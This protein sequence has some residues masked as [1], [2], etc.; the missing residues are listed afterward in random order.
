MKK[1]IA[2]RITM[3]TL[4]M[5]AIRAIPA[6]AATSPALTAG[7][8]NI[9]VN[10]MSTADPFPVTS[11]LDDF[12]RTDGSPGSNWAAIDPLYPVPNIANGQLVAN[13]NASGYWTSMPPS[14]QEV[15]LHLTDPPVADDYV[16]MVRIGGTLATGSENGYC[17][18]FNPSLSTVTIKR[19]DG[20][21]KTVIGGPYNVIPGQWIGFRAAGSTLTA[22]SS[23]DDVTWNA[24][25]SATDATY[26]DGFIG[27][28]VTAFA[29][30]SQ[31]A[32]DDFGGTPGIP[33]PVNTAV[34]TIS[35]TTRPGS[36]LTA[37]KGSWNNSPTSYAYQW[38]R[39]GSNIPVATNPTYKIKTTDQGTTVTVTVTAT[40]A[41][42]S[43]TATRP[44]RTFPPRRRPTSRTAR[45]STNGTRTALEESEHTTTHRQVNR[46]RPS[47][48]RTGSTGWC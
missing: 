18:Y 35:G 7:D 30:G 3:A 26:T 12:A 10:Y 27:W 46:S 13:N 42:G 24:V 31:F 23:S 41:N 36:T 2:V 5:L 19:S 1:H 20:G 11:V 21:D 4:A 45:R 33:P 9:T 22:Y 32:I 8:I 43:A 48:G 28:F 34:P 47:S 14:D 40:N 38:K 25:G 44:G 16:L 17:A 15:F 6:V 37:S 39:N 29:S